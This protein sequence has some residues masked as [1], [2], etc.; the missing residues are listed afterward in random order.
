MSFERETGMHS[1]IICRGIYFP[2]FLAQPIVAAVHLHFNAILF[3]P[4]TPFYFISFSP[5]SA[6]YA[7]SFSLMIDDPRV[8]SF[9]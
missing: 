1:I 5:G 3:S 7:S 9:V 8:E 4:F 2:P 6:Q